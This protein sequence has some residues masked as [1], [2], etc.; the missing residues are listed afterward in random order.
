M[1]R[2]TKLIL[3]Y[4]EV[5]LPIF[6]MFGE[7]IFHQHTMK[8]HLITILS[9]A[10]VISSCKQTA[11]Q[12]SPEELAAQNKEMIL[13]G[14]NTWDNRSILTHVLLP[15]ELGLVMELRDGMSG[16]ILPMAFT[17]NRSEGS[18]KVETIAHTADGSYTDFILHW[19]GLDLHVQAVAEDDELNVRLTRQDEVYN[20]ADLLIVKNEFFYNKEGKVEIGDVFITTE[21]E[22]TIYVTRIPEGEPFR[23]GDN[24]IAVKLE[25]TTYVTC[26]NQMSAEQID[27]RIEQA[28]AVWQSDM[29]EYGAYAESYNAIRNAV[30]WNVVYDHVNM[31]PVIP[32]SRPWSYGWGDSKP[33]GWIRFCWDNFFVAYMQSMESKELAFSEAIEMCNYIDTFGF[34]PNYIGPF[35]RASRDRSQ[36]PVGGMMVKEIYK[37][38]PERWF[39]EKTFD[40][41]LKWNRWWPENRDQD[42]YLAWG[43]TPFK[44]VTGDRRDNIQNI[45]QGARY[46]SGLDNSPMYDGVKFD[47]TLHMMLLGDVGLMGLYVGDCEALFEMAEIL[48]RSEEAAELKERAGYYREKIKTMWDEETGMFLNKKT[49]TGELSKRISPTNFYALIAEAATRDQAERM[50]NEHFYNPDEFWG[51]YIMPSIAR[52]DTAYTGELYWRGSIWAPMNFL[53]YCGM[54]NYDLSRAQKDLSEKSKKLLMKE[55]LDRGFIRENYNAETG[56]PPSSRSDHFYHWGALLGMINMIQEGFVPPTEAPI[57]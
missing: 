11:K 10:L 7:N 53:V 30:N 51:A 16:K 22:D 17:G 9:L 39:L 42:G 5:D 3:N 13:S 47:T 23:F 50:I 27:A 12:S 4:Q 46:E 31:K 26:G 41:L 19:Q 15:E 24:A 54:R 33:G 44:S 49:D 48:G 18:E 40:Q 2:L 55:W 28:E 1:I 38:H 57:E 56:G 35:N 37:A 34:V 14:W 20:E 43:S 45:I 32:V 8:N 25:K 29:E 52:N 6:C 21:V 36:P